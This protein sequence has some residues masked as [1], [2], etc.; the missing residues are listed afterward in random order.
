MSL[1]KNIEDEEKDIIAYPSLRF[2]SM[3]FLVVFL[4]KAGPNNKTLLEEN[5]SLILSDWELFAFTR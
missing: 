1:R 3:C 5:K 4:S 2:D